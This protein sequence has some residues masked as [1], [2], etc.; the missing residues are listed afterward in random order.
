MSEDEKL[1][2][3]NKDFSWLTRA[4]VSQLVRE[5]PAHPFKPKDIVFDS[6]LEKDKGHIYDPS[7]R[8]SKSHELWQT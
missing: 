8:A 1:L 6:R 5:F 3:N 2:F 4:E 7:V